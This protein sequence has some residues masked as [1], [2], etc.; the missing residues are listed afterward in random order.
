MVVAR[1][2]RVGSAGPRRKG[3]TMG[4]IPRHVCLVAVL[5]ATFLLSAPPVARARPRGPVPQAVASGVYLLRLETRSGAVV[6]KVAV[7]R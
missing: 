5:A 7:A 3:T 4:A 1:P 2:S 6:R